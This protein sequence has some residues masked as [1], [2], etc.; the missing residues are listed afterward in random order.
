MRLT[1]DGDATT[2]ESIIDLVP[3]EGE[4]TTRF[5]NEINGRKELR[6]V[7]PVVSIKKA[8]RQEG[9]GYRI[10][11]LNP[12][13]RLAKSRPNKAILASLNDPEKKRDFHL[14]NNGITAVCISFE[15]NYGNQ[16]QLRVKG[17][18]IVNGQQTTVTLSDLNDESLARVYVDMKLIQIDWTM[19]EGR[20]FA[21][22]VS[23]ATNTQS[24]LRPQ[25]YAAFDRQQEALQ[26]DF[27]RTPNP[28][29]YEIKPQMWNHVLT[30][31]QKSHFKTG[32]RKRHVAVPAIAQVSVAMQGE[33][34]QAMDRIRYTLNEFSS[35][36]GGEREL[37]NKAFPT[38]V[39]REQLL[40]PYKILQAAEKSSPRPIAYSKYH[41][42]Y[43]VSRFLHD[44]YEIEEMGLFSR[45]RSA[46]L[47]NWV[48]TPGSSFSNILRAAIQATRVSEI[49]ARRT[50]NREFPSEP[51]NSRNFFR[52]ELNADLQTSFQS[53][54]ETGMETVNSDHDSEFFSAG[55]PPA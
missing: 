21:N 6:A 54:L 5:S 29:Y 51:W 16:N 7:V 55:L 20:K 47:T 44:H 18:Q 41:V 3:D 46:A 22:E 13:G 28:W 1:S 30:D 53:D 36:A 17:F 27:E 48:E 12:R 49:I 42:L 34:G 9:A 25:D 4:S 10:F 26:K 11:A 35:S 23:A 31:Q 38:G 2:L 15:S 43:H 39:R 32:Q 8:F 19:E 50:W 14:L 33:P 37:L 52:L 40:L 24:A 45:D